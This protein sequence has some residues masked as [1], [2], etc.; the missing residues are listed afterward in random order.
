VESRFETPLLPLH[1]SG[2][3]LPEHFV[4][5]DFCIPVCTAAFFQGLGEKICLPFLLVLLSNDI[6][7]KWVTANLAVLAEREDR[8][9]PAVPLP[10]PF[11]PEVWSFFRL[12]QAF[13]KAPALNV[14]QRPKQQSEKWCTRAAVA[15][16]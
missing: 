1:R 4:L 9:I 7:I 6:Q 8:S 13:G 16:S 10:L 11:Y 5:P 2:S 12:Q 3:P 14:Y 15:T